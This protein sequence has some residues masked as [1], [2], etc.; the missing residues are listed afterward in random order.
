M[1]EPVYIGFGANLGD[2]LM[3]IVTALRR[4]AERMTLTAVSSVYETQPMG[5]VEQPDFLNGVACFVGELTPYKVLEACLEVE[6]QGGRQR[7]VRWGPRTIDLDLLLYGEREIN[8]PKLTVPH[9]RMSERRFVLLP[10]AELAPDAVIPGSRKTVRQ[11]A[12]C[13]DDGGAILLYR[14]SEQLM[15]LIREG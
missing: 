8:E 15:N 14:T 2:R 5:V 12:E 4:L 1:N 6:T 10:L 3:N 7:S 11:A 13:V 9:P